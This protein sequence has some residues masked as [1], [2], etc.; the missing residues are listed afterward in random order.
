LQRCAFL[1]GVIFTKTLS[2]QQS[3]YKACLSFP[4][5]RCA[6]KRVTL[7]SSTVPRQPQRGTNARLKT[8]RAGG[9][10]GPGEDQARAAL[11]NALALVGAAHLQEILTERSVLQSWLC[12]KPLTPV[13]RE[14]PTQGAVR[15]VS[16]LTSP[17]KQLSHMHRAECNSA[18][19]WFITTYGGYQRHYT[20]H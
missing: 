12:L 15:L 3:F 11:R 18:S 16:Q 17:E 2:I 6:S 4:S 19:E 5:C 1:D 7:A 14:Q 9:S 20:C 13:R 10:R 8:L